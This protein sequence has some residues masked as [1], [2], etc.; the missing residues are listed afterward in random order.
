MHNP[1]IQPNLL[2]TKDTA[3]LFPLLIIGVLIFIGGLSLI[4]LADDAN[5]PFKDMYLIPYVVL[6]GVVIAAPNVYLIY[7]DQFNL[8]HPLVF[9]AW[10]YFVPAFFLGSLILAS[11]LSQ[12]FYLTFVEDERYNLP[13]TIIYIALGYGGLTLGYFFSYGKN[14]GEKIKRKLPVWNWKPEK[15]L[16]PG[17]ILLAI[18]WGNSIVAFAF[19]ILGYQKVDQIGEYD[20][21]IFLL[22]LFWLEA[23]LLL[24]LCI[25][26]TEKLNISH[27][28]V[29]GLLLAT[30]LLK[31]V[32]Q[33]N[34]GS[35]I[36]MFFLVACAFVFSVKRIETRHRIY[37]GVLLIL[38]L[39][40]GMI[41]GTAFRSVKQ[42][43]S[44]VSVEEYIGNIAVTFDKIS[45]QDLTQNLAE[46]FAAIAERF[47]SVSS[48]AV[49]VSNYEKL[50]PFEESYGL[51]D[52]IWNDTITA[53]IPRPL[54]KEKPVGSDPR[55][56]ADLYF[57]FGENSFAVTP[58]GDLLRNFGP[59]GIPLGMFFLGF[60][61]SVIYTSLVENQEFSFWRTTL[62]YVLLTGVS[63]E[64]FY[65]TIM[66]YL[67]KYGMFAVIGL[68]FV[69]IFHGTDG[70]NVK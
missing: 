50:E 61:L 25:F 33:G 27:Y 8:F 18:G 57:S 55:K 63:Y 24:W 41:Y 14:I 58:M 45:D 29:L 44:R 65:G 3:L 17:V 52:N 16:L 59:V 43:E 49:I 56:F 66:P 10:S 19:G 46:G 68:I 1:K 70:K 13:L 67:I 20:G 35:L 5:N 2:Q 11:G 30:T 40:F 38:T 4:Y 15:V 28:F 36:Q 60:V 69:R 51:N 31:A 42:N 39:V 21:L 48:L 64:G 7:K 62:F 37:G 53:F 23:S 34:R 32:F 47:E 22:T 54:W 6:L 12:P 26:R 9:A